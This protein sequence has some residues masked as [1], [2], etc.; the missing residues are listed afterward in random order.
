M[1]NV[2]RNLKRFMEC[3]FE[4]FNDLTWQEQ[5]ELR[6]KLVDEGKLPMG[7][8]AMPSAG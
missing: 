3:L 6:G 8:V 1:Q 4:E 2:K 5:S 7:G